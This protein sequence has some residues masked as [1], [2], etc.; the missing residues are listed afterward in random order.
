MKLI[1]KNK[2]TRKLA[3][4]HE[5]HTALYLACK[6]KCSL[7][8]V[9]ALLVSAPDIVHYC[10]TEGVTPLHIASSQGN[11]ELIQLLLKY[12]APID[13]QDFDGD[14]PLH[15]TI[16]SHRHEAMVT[17]LYAGADPEITNHPG[18][19]TPF[20][21]ACTRDYL[22]N[23]ESLFPFVSDINQSTLSGD[24]PLHYALLGMSQRTAHF[25]LD[26]G[27]DPHIKNAVGHMAIDL[28]VNTGAACVLQRLLQVTDEEQISKDIIA[29]ACKPHI[30]NFPVLE[31][32][33]T[34]DLGPDFFYIVKSFN[35]E[36]IQDDF[37][38]F[39]YLTN[40]PLNH[41]LYICGYIHK[42][43]PE[44]FRE[45]F[46][47]FLMKGVHVNAYNTTECPPLVYV[48]FINYKLSP[49]CFL[50]VFKILIDNG[51]DVD[52]CSFGRRFY[53]DISI[54][55]A[56]LIALRVYPAAAP[57]MMPYSLYNEPGT[58]L[59]YAI[60]NNIIDVFSL[61]MQGQIL[62]LIDKDYCNDKAVSLQYTVPR[63]KHLC[64]YKIRSIFRHK[65]IGG[66]YK[67]SQFFDDVKQLPLPPLIQKYL[68][69]IET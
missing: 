67:T 15:E 17:L 6:N 29:E 12:G 19:Y 69:Y 56:F 26:H 40:A 50:E 16:L 46:Y 32:L 9:K 18:L 58:Y 38:P 8:T 20:H 51:C 62:S 1:L 31:T 64:R 49:T 30:F 23:V 45:F 36:M 47:L 44:K 34:S 24:T 63:L 7:K 59:L 4:T 33:L 5:G 14:T 41:Y 27:A 42:Q 53:K 22:P 55:D 57:V 13:A 66:T 2:K 54:S 11:V 35:T 65:T 10:S 39:K 61:P 60:E 25:L 3:E 21:L 43:S 37:L 48:Q 52:Y 28:A 68:I